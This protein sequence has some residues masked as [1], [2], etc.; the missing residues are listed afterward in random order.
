MILFVAR[1]G[2]G[3][4]HTKTELCITD[5]KFMSPKVIFMISRIGN[6]VPRVVA[7]GPVLLVCDSS[8]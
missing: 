1:P 4:W 5:C 3:T 7:A 6:Y 2:K 8:I